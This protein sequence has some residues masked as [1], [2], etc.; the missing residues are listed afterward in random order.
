MFILSAILR[1]AGN[2][3]FIKVAVL[4]VNR[5][6][7]WN[8]LEISTF[9]ARLSSHCRMPFFRR[10]LYPVSE[11]GTRKYCVL[12]YDLTDSFNKSC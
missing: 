10:L 6:T 8:F 7:S 12:S 11:Y 4:R 9:R 2:F 5:A 3:L 1:Q